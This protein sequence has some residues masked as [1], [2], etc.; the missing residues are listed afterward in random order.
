MKVKKVINACR[1][2]LLTL[3]PTWHEYALWQPASILGDSLNVYPHSD[4]TIIATDLYSC[5]SDT[6][7]INIIPDSVCLNSVGINEVKDLSSDYK[8]FPN[9]VKSGEYIQ[10]EFTP[11][12]KSNSD[13]YH[14][15]LM[16]CS[17][18]K[19][20]ITENKLVAGNVVKIKLPELRQGFYLLY[21]TNGTKTYRTKLLITD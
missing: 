15:E 19:V 2:S 20:A 4:T 8:L 5:L 21:F 17:G 11:Q 6:F 7:A 16:D 10:I 3:F 9:P 12:L 14:F 1:D 18:K 13:N